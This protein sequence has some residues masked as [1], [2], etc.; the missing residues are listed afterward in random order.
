MFT[1]GA[2]EANHLILWGFALRYHTQGCRVL[3]GTTEHKSIIETAQALTEVN[4]VSVAE[5]PVGSDGTVDLEDLKRQLSSAPHTPTLVCLMHINNEVPARHPI[6]AISTLCKRH[7]A[8]F[9]CD[10]VQ[11]FVRESI[12][13]AQQTFGSY[14]ISSHK[15]YGPKGCGVLVIGDNPLATRLA[16]AYRGGSQERG[17]RP[18]TVNTLAIV[19]AAKAIEEHSMQRIVRVQHM[20][21]CANIFVE[22]MTQRSKDFRLTTPLVKNAPGI[23]SFYIDGID[24]PTILAATPDLCINR[25]SSC[26]GAGGERFSHVPKALGLPIEVQANVLRASFGEIISQEDSRQ[27]AV[28]LAQRIL[29]LK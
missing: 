4:G 12:D 8:F 20:T 25:G 10:G 16:P 22:E 3:F 9:H 28:I 27:A 24:A 21:R 23:V 2:A 26:I 29:T 13:F 7:N 18:G 14:V 19:G 11:G 1:S 17:L 5:V 15:I 6:E